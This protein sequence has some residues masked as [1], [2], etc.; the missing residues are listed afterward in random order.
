MIFS[1]ETYVKLLLSNFFA[2]YEFE[3][4]SMTPFDLLEEKSFPR[5][6]I[7]LTTFA[8]LNY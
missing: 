7:E 1:S 3:I 6:G 2:F 4:L 5:I 8:I